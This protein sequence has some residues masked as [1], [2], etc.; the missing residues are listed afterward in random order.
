MAN[1]KIHLEHVCF[2]LSGFEYFKVK[3]Y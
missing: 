1:T 3:T 2:L